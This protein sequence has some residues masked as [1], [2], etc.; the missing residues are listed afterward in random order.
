[1]YFQIMIYG[2]CDLLQHGSTW[3]SQTPLIETNCLPFKDWPSAL[4]MICVYL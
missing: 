2:I 3:Y 1:M 4:R